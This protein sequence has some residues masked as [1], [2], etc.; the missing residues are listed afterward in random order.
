MMW[1]QKHQYGTYHTLTKPDEALDSL[2]F[3]L[4]NISMYG[5][6]IFPSP[7]TREVYFVPAV[8]GWKFNYVF[9]KLSV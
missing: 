5:T 7:I 8:L 6:G 4:N 9:Q 3:Y 1:F 2:S